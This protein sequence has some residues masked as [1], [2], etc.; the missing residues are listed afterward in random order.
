M[1]YNLFVIYLIMLMKKT[2]R[3]SNFLLLLFLSLYFIFIFSYFLFIFSIW[4]NLGFYL[5]INVRQLKYIG[6]IFNIFNCLNKENKSFSN[7]LS[8]FF[9]HYFHFYLLFP[10]VY[11]LNMRQ[12]KC[13]VLFGMHLIDVLMK[14]KKCSQIFS[15]SLSVCLKFCYLIVSSLNF[16]T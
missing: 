1:Y 5:Y 16:K 12:L 7:F 3:F 9:T 14:K 10:F 6:F 2:K 4:D 8:F 13:E 15:F 11:I